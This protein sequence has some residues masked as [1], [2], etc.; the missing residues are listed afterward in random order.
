M[1]TLSILTGITSLSLHLSESFLGPKKTGPE[2]P[3]ERKTL[4]QNNEIGYKNLP[5]K[6]LPSKS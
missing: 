6:R 5:R 3:H 2:L 1:F 4:Y